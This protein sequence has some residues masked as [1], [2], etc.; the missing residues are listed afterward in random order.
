M[1]DC[2]KEQQVAHTG[3]V[4]EMQ[5]EMP[6]G[7]RD[8]MSLIFHTTDNVVFNIISGDSISEVG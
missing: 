3:D 4:L 2:C 8:L 6:T 7:A 1:P 5:L